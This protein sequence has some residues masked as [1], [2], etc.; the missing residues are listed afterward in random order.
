ML[1]RMAAA[2][3]FA[4]VATAK[5]T[6]LPRLVL[7]FDVNE[8]ILVTDPVGA[9]TTFLIYHLFPVPTTSLTHL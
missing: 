6:A 9:L 2:T 4:S 8:T 7:H 3:T 1:K 5:K